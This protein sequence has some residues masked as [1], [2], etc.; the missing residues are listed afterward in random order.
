MNTMGRRKS[1][2]GGKNSLVFGDDTSEVKIHRWALNFLDRVELGNN[3]RMTFFENIFHS[4]GTD[5]LR[6]ACCDFLELI[7]LSLL[8][9]LHG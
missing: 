5:D 7:L 4:M 3:A 8:L 9:E 1:P 2:G 6:G